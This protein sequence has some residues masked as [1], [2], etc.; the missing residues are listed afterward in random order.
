MLSWLIV[1]AFAVN[2]RL[3]IKAYTAVITAQA[4]V[5]PK[6]Q[7]PQQ[8]PMTQAAAEQLPT[9]QVVDENQKHRLIIT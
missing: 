4:T 6:V 1:V 3:G 7:L 8:V 9:A 5:A 2:V